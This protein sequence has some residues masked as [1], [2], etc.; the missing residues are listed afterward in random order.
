MAVVLPEN[1]DESAFTNDVGNH[2]ELYDISHT[3]YS[4]NEHRHSIFYQ[5][6]VLHGIDG[7]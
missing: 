3:L 2:S 7:M 5:I 6:G 4:N 1:F